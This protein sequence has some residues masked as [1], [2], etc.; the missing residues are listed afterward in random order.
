VVSASRPSTAVSEK[1]GDLVDNSDVHTIEANSEYPA[2]EADTKVSSTVQS[3]LSAAKVGAAGTGEFLHALSQLTMQEDGANTQDDE[4]SVLTEDNV[5]KVDEESASQQ[6]P[7]EYEAWNGKLHVFF[8]QFF[9]PN[10]ENHQ[11]LEREVEK[12]K[13]EEQERL[14]ILHVKQ[15]AERRRSSMK[16]TIDALESAATD[17]GK[18]TVADNDDLETIDPDD[19]AQCSSR[20]DIPPCS[21]SVSNSEVKARKGSSRKGSSKSKKRKS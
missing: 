4:A 10:W 5:R 12:F 18:S 13:V 8:T 7:D 19:D 2:S 9:F 1:C 11:M 6:H 17:A 21:S 14:R 16:Q 3:R 20:S 15:E